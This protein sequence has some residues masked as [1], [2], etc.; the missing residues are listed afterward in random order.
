MQTCYNDFF[1]CEHIQGWK[2]LQHVNEKIA[3]KVDLVRIFFENFSQECFVCFY[4][5]ICP[6][7]RKTKLIVPVRKRSLFS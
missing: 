5:F 4:H 1:T 6:F 7:V 3:N 2:S